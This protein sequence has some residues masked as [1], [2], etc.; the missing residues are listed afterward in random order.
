MTLFSSLSRASWLYPLRGIKFFI[1]H[2]YLWPL[3]RARLL[4]ISLLSAFIYSILFTLAYLPQVAFLAIFHG[5][6]AWVNGLFLVL[7]EG[8]VI[9]QILFEAFFVDE[10]LVDVFDAVLISQGEEHLVATSRIVYP[11]VDHSQGGDGDGDGNG[12]GDAALSRNPKQRLGKP[13]MSAVYAPFSLRQIVEFIVLL[14]LNLVPV[15]GT[16]MF[17]ILTGYR[18]GPLQHWRYF[19]LRGFN[20]SERK[21]FVVKRRL[22]YTWFG[23]VA[24]ILQLVPMLSMFL[25]LTTAAGSA[26]WAAD[27]E[28]RRR[29]AI[30]RAEAVRTSG[31][32][33]LP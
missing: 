5:S 16:P 10:T 8:A 1:F 7:G 33:D 6:G 14:P 27:L 9:V 28:R 11:S 4:S 20:K 17:L 3:F 21:K 22:R 19:E 13:I 2:P 31:Y 18:A 32:R 12:N 25:L 15:A 30:E 23:T 26:L 24:L 29:M